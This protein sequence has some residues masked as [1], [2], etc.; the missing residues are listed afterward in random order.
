MMNKRGA[1]MAVSTIIL[2]VL[3]LAVLVMLILGFTMGF[4]K[5]L[6]F[7][8]SSNVDSIV[9]GCQASC[10]TQSVYGYCT[11]VRNLIDDTGKKVDQPCVNLSNGSY[12]QYGI[13]QCSID[14][15]TAQ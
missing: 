14:C 9:N 5:I 4:G 12:S 1:E 15:P 13:K 11:Q 7:L 6:P 3:G 8:S 10:A 2:L